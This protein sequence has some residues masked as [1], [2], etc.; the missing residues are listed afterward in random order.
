MVFSSE[1]FLFVFLPLFMGIYW[2]SP[3]G[4]R[5]YLILFGSLIFYGWWQPI[6]LLLLLLVIVSTYYAGLW[7]CDDNRNECT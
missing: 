6:Y 5:L 3:R 4:V 7:C 1:I 2:L